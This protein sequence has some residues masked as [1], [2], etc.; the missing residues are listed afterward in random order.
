MEG[1]GRQRECASDP[2]NRTA[3]LKTRPS[4]ES[5]TYIAE[6]LGVVCAVRWGVSIV[7]LA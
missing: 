1:V 2:H 7:V 4:E 6:S 3:C 5:K